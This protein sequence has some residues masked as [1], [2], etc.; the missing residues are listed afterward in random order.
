MS[1]NPT[2]AARL[3]MV[4][5]EVPLGQ[6]KTS[7]DRPARERYPQ[8]PFQRNPGSHG[9]IGHKIFDLVMVKYVA[10]DDQSM[11]RAGQTGG[12]MFAVKRRVF[13]LPNN[14]AFFAVFDLESLPFLLLKLTRINQ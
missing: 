11:A 7:F 12:A 2:P 10:G 14:R 13:N 8:H 9:H 5:P 6:F 4:H 3:K 1:M